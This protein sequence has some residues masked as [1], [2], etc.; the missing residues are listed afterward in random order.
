M[1]VVG[2]GSIGRRI[3]LLCAQVG[4]GRIVLVDPDSVNEVNLGT[5][6]FRPDQ[7]GR[8]KVDA[9]AE[10][11]RSLSPGMNVVPIAAHAPH[12]HE[13]HRPCLARNGS[14]GDLLFVTTDTQSSRKAVLG[15]LAEA[16]RT[17]DVLVDVRML[18]EVFQVHADLPP[19]SHYGSTLFDDAEALPGTCSTRTT[20]HGA[21]CAASVATSVAMRSLRGMDVP[22][23]VECD[24]LAMTLQSTHRER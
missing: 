16:R 9:T 1:V 2:C 14:W 17:P 12:R 23:L 11:C 7:I 22:C 18:G 19:F 10:D 3:A 8:M 5:Q 24:L 6:G 15:A 4:V 21:A 20:G 13:Q